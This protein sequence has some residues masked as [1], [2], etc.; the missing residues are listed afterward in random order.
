[1]HQQQGFGFA[2]RVQ[3]QRLDRVAPQLFERGNALMSIDHQIALFLRNDWND[4]NRRL[5]AGF[6]QRR[7][8]APESRRVTDPEMLQAVVQLM[9]LECLRHG[10]QYAPVADWSFASAPGCCSELF[11]DQRDSRGIGLSLLVGIVCR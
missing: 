2:H 1:M 10:F 8:Q 4:D 11:S 7:Q 5:L 3:N 6:S 9:K